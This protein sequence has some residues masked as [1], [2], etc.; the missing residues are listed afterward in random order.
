MRARLGAVDYTRASA[1]AQV[2]ETRSRGVGLA[3]WALAVRYEQQ[4][5]FDGPKARRILPVRLG[6][7]RV[8]GRGGRSCCQFATDCHHRRGA[9]ASLCLR[10]PR[11]AS[12]GRIGRIPILRPGTLRKGPPGQAAGL[13]AL[14]TGPA[15]TR[16]FR[17][18]PVCPA[19]PAPWLALSWSNRPL[20]RG[21]C[22]V[23]C[24]GH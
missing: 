5:W 24:P 12:F 18:L 14:A 9:T 19:V 21:R 15:P 10:L 4:F 8:P 13:S 20:R 16:P 23:R 3:G 2:S 7:C 6:F 11:Q 1:R 22:C 17:G